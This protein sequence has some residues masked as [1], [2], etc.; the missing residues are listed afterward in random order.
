MRALT[1]PNPAVP[2]GQ[3]QKAAQIN[4]GKTQRA[5]LDALTCACT[6]FIKAMGATEGVSVISPTTLIQILVS[7]IFVAFSIRQQT[8]CNVISD[9]YTVAA[10]APGATSTTSATSPINRHL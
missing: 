1:A 8:V 10:D 5:A 6:L 2:Y 7:T 3:Q 4:D 9:A